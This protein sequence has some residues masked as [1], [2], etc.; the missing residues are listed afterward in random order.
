MIILV[1]LV[2]TFLLLVL[3]NFNFIWWYGKDIMIGD[4]YGKETVFELGNKDGDW[5][6]VADIN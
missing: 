6:Q 1:Q 5:D 2:K 3:G 4:N